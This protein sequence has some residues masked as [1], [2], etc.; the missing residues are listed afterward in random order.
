LF[1]TTKS[2]PNIGPHSNCW[3]WWGRCM[4]KRVYCAHKRAHDGYIPK[5][6]DENIRG[7]YDGTILGAYDGYIHH[8]GTS[9][10]PYDL[11]RTLSG[12]GSRTHRDARRR[13]HN[14]GGPRRIHSESFRR[15]H[16][17][18]LPVR[19]NHSGDHDGCQTV[20]TSLRDRGSRCDMTYAALECS[21]RQWNIP[22]D[23]NV[24][25]H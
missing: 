19:R 22:H 9:P 12:V 21:M 23:Q 14:S 16:S 5:V 18:V 8:G 20:I 25:L 24:T 6:S 17:W 4:C 13:T 2:E 11:R 15:N 7:S 1:G 3:I 10:V